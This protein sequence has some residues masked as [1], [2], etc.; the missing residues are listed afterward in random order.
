MNNIYQKIIIAFSTISLC[1]CMVGPDFEKPTMESMPEKYSNKVDGKLLSDETKPRKVS[2]EE[3]AKWWEVFG[4][5][6]L[7][8]LMEKAFKNNFDIATASAKIKQAR[9]TLGITQSGF[10]PTLDVNGSFR[11]GGQIRE[12]AST[13]SM[14]ANASWEV[15]IFGGTRRGIES[16]VE[17]YKSALVDKCAVKIAVASEV[18][19]TYFLYRSYEQELIITRSNLQTQRKTFEVTKQRRA[20]GFESDIDVVRASSQVENTSSQIP[21]LESQ[22]MLARHS[23]ELLLAVPTGSLKKE[24]STP[25]DLPELENFIPVGV[26]A[27]LVQRRPDVVMAEHKLH[28]A[29]AKI[30]EATADWYPKFSIT[31]Q[32]G[33]TAPDI[34]KLDQNRYGTWS[35]GPTISWNI[36]QAGKTY[37]NVELRKAVAEEAGISWDKTV[38]T[39]I[40]EVE[41]SLVSASKERERIGYINKVVQS[42]KKAFELSSKLYT[43]G[44]IEFLDLL[45]AQRSMLTSQ[46]SQVA[47]RQ[48][49]ISHIISLYKSLG[50]GW[51]LNDLED[52]DSDKKWLI[53]LDEKKNENN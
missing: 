5:K 25:Q 7:S 21:R 9:S 4:D 23:L 46:Q 26:P 10:F 53:F 34:G 19:R 49:F 51:D 31:G 18:A 14:G 11:E 48:L 52:N 22:M 17:D 15:D 29:I 13:Y 44:E 24:L 27:Q 47:S 2:D 37:F 50:G 42:N 33:Y 3:L 16:A 12:S 30:G 1:G 38:L 43:E 6:T 36:F 35:V 20:N 8:A 39:A 45:E 32:I 41:D 28:S 40:K